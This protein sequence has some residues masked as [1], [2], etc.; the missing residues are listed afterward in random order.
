MNNNTEKSFNFIKSKLDSLPTPKSG[1]A[2]YK[3]TKEKGLQLYV[4]T[5][6]IKT[7][8]FRKKLNG[9]DN[10][11]TFG[12]YGDISIEN[13]RNMCLKA[14]ADLA[15][16]INI[17]SKSKSFKKEQ[18]LKEA[19][20]EYIELYSKR[21][22]KEKTVNE[23][24]RYQNLY[25]KPLLNYKVSAINRDDIIRL[26]NN[27]TDNNGGYI[28]N[29]VIEFLRAMYNWKIKNQNF[30]KQNP[31]SAIKLNR[32]IKKDR[33][34]LPDEKERLIKSLDEEE[35]EII[36]DFFFI[37][38]LTGVRKSNIFAM[39]WED[40][41][42]KQQIWRIPE[43]KNGEPHIVPL[44]DEVI[45]ILNLRKKNNSILGF[46]NS[47][48][49]FPSSNSK[50]GHIVEAKTAWKRILKR[51]NIEN[52]TIHDLRRTMGSY[53]TISGANLQTVGKALGHKNP[54]STAIYS[55]LDVD[56]VRL[57]MQKAGELIFAK[58]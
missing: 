4:T 42:L 37:A 20:N 2:Y 44:L 21:H 50:V 39:R 31:A 22:K 3:D 11:I 41:N 8:C 54:S 48:Y 26:H 19:I 32:E 27:I 7:F 29:R 43:T 35:N 30:D 55:R 56:T 51:A 33:F 57:S 49:V 25:L 17:F 34:L 14:K 9:R 38:L 24:I 47:E 46:K 10:I 45:S 40:I 13:A 6:G 52:L 58:N 5:N 16:G 23:E 15:N 28:A 53:M 36:R 18:V 1:R 12:K